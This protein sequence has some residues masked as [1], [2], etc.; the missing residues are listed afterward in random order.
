MSIQSRITRGIGF[1]ALAVATFG[2]LQTVPVTPA[3]PLAGGGI[4]R[5]I[6][7][8]TKAKHVKLH[9]NT[10]QEHDTYGYIGI[11]YDIAAQHKVFAL[12]KTW[13]EQSTTGIITTKRTFA[14]IVNPQ[15]VSVHYQLNVATAQNQVS[16]GTI[17]TKVIESAGHEPDI[18]V[19]KDYLTTAAIANASSYQN[20]HIEGRIT[21]S[22]PELVSTYYQINASTA[23][24][25]EISG[26]ISAKVLPHIAVKI[27]S[28]YQ[29]QSISGKITTDNDEMLMVL[30]A[31]MELDGEIT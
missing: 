22:V 23:Q 18:S 13:Q 14:D 17:T 21:L 16:R 31:L 24:N 10:W 26:K 1:G 30:L 12:G 28:T 6:P 8:Y 15:L 29:Q 27:A 9:G 5:E 3:I 11:K 20:Q 25:Q 4:Y 19:V 7:T 2:L